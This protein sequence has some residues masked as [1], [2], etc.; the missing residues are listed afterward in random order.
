MYPW[1]NRELRPQ[2][3]P[4]RFPLSQPVLLL[5][6]FR[7]QLRQAQLTVGLL[8]AGRRV[9][10]GCVG[11]IGSAG[12]QRRPRYDHFTAKKSWSSDE[13]KTKNTGSK[14]MKKKNFSWSTIWNRVRRSLE[15]KQELFY[16]PRQ[17]VIQTGL[18]P[19]LPKHPSLR[20]SFVL[21]RKDNMIW[22]H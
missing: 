15:K 19:A 3:L 14:K 4:V 5:S 22:Q 13:T 10:A 8:Q 17:L 11:S 16:Q 2:S 1:T 18:R 7:Y 6:I 21:T 12:S 9:L 20:F